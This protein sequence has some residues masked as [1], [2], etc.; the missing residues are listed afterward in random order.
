MSFEFTSSPYTLKA[1][2]SANGRPYDEDRFRFLVCKGATFI[3]VLDGHGGD[4]CVNII[5]SS[6]E[7]IIAR[8][9]TLLDFTDIQ[10]M[11]NATEQMYTELTNITNESTSGSCMAMVIILPDNTMIAS[12]LGDSRIYVFNH[13]IMYI[14]QDHDPISDKDGVRARGGRVSFLNGPRVV[15][16]LAV[17]R[18]FGD[19]DIK[20]VGR[21]PTIKL[22][23]KDWNQFLITSDCLTNAI[24]TNERNTNP[25]E[26]QLDNEGYQIH[27]PIHELQAEAEP[28]VT[29]KII[30]IFSSALIGT[31]TK[32]E[33]MSVCV[34]SFVE[35]AKTYPD[36]Y[37]IVCGS[38]I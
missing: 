20:G 2:S 19:K 31:E 7:E 24:N 35:Q 4:T 28:A 36:N 11:L 5:T 38:R 34:A 3:I 30:K 6:L 8:I 12:H 17:A 14:S 10:L 26:P 9:F 33:A 16:G 29:E 1:I 21:Q 32:E 27:K 15:G 22:I 23:G 18:A 25:I 13:Q 37:T